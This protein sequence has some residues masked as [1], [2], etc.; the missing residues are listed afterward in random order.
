MI[1]STGYAL[2]MKWTFFLKKGL[3]NGRKMIYN[4]TG[5]LRYCSN[6]NHKQGGIDI[7]PFYGDNNVCI[8]E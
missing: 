7:L 8:M 1:K 2:S 5:L 3:I 6:K 4:G